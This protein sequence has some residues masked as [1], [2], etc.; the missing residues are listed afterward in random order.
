MFIKKKFTK[1]RLLLTKVLQLS[2]RSIENYSH[3]MAVAQDRLQNQSKPGFYF[4]KYVVNFL[5]N[6]SLLSRNRTRHAKLNHC[7]SYFDYRA[8]KQLPTQC[9]LF[10][11]RL[12]FQNRKPTDDNN[13]N[14]N[15]L[16]LN[17]VHLCIK[18]VNMHLKQPLFD[19]MWEK[20][21]SS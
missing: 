21:N 12:K 15:N 18:L 19:D 3:L 11:V 20:F 8:R 13:N 14:R 6:F 16:K 2:Q 9:P 17:H 1:P 7:K 4:D 5:L 10:Y